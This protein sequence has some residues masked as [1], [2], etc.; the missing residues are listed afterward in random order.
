[1]NTLVALGTTAAYAYSVAAIVDHELGANIL[2][3]TTGH[4]MPELYFDTSTTVIGLILLGKYLEARAKGRTSEAIRHLIGLQPKTARVLRDGVEV[5]VAIEAVRLGD[6]VIVRPGERIPV[7]GRVVDG[8]SAVDESMI[9]G[10]PIPVEKRAGDEVI[11]ATVNKTGSFRFEATRV[12]RDTALAQ[13]V[14]LIQ[15]AQGSKAPIQRLADLVSAYFVPAVIVLALA[16]GAI[17]L[18]YGPSPAFSYAFKTFVTVLIIACPCAMGLATPTAIMV[19][20]GKGAENGI[21]IR[22]AEA[23]ETAHK[24]DTIILD[25]TGT[26]TAGR[27]HV[28]DIVVRSDV[29]PRVLQLAASAERG[30]EHPLGEAIIAGMFRAADVSAVITSEDV[31]DH[32]REGAARANVSVVFSHAEGPG[33]RRLALAPEIVD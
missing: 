23:L 9:S 25:K 26:L 22:S 10:E 15:E 24:L 29:G 31:K 1:M 14:R 18:I 16:T 20:T 27:P 6:V 5:D 12:G 28:T 21:L 8:Y 13:I 11:G 2:T 32:I 19:G 30:S 7:D 33:A 4:G 17:W 3:A